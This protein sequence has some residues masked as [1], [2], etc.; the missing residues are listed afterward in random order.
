[1]DI[2]LWTMMYHKPLVGVIAK[3]GKTR[4]SARKLVLG[5]T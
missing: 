2:Q 1:M 5:F 4:F 3:D